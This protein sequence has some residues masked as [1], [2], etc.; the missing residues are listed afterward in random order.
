MKHSLR[1]FKNFQVNILAL[2]QL[3]LFNR[4]IHDN[5]YIE[6]LAHMK[7]K[8]HTF[9][10]KWL[11]QFLS[12]MSDI[13]DTLPW[14]VHSP[15]TY[16]YDHKAKTRWLHYHPCRLCIMIVLIASGVLTLE[17]RN[18]QKRVSIQKIIFKHFKY[19]INLLPKQY[20]I[21]QLEFL[22]IHFKSKPKKIIACF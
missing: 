12:R 4:Y 1:A 15:R 9:N 21:F 5:V 17:L 11:S 14:L 18:L 3:H 20:N 2:L 16:T 10:L 22:N 7:F 13:L 6:I 19:N 8:I